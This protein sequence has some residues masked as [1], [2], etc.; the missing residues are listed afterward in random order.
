L[1]NLKT[2]TNWPNG[3]TSCLYNC[4]LIGQA[5]GCAQAGLNLTMQPVGILQ[6]IVTDQRD[7]P[8][9]ANRPNSRTAK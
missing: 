7:Q 2:V 1:D 6:P 9:A 5:T 8:M 4:R 3:Q